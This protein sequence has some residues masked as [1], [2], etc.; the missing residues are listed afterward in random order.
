M[1]GGIYVHFPYCEHRCTYCDFVIATPRI[2]PQ[3]RFTEALLAELKLRAPQLMGPAKSL[4]LGGG[5]PSL[6]APDELARV[7]AAIR[8]EPGLCEGAEVTLEANPNDLN[9]ER[10]ALFKALGVNRISLGVQSFTDELLAT[11]GRTHTGAQAI[12]ACRAIENAAFASYSIDLIFGLPGQ[13]LSLWQAD[14]S[15]ALELDPPHLSVYGLT[16]EP[17]TPLAAQVER[18]AIALPD[19]SAQAEMMFDARRR[20]IDAGYTHYE[21]SSYAK[22]G[23][24]ARHNSAYWRMTPYLGLGPGAHAFTPPRR[25][26]NLSRTS[27]YIN[28]ALRGDPTET[29]ED[30]DEATLS[31]ERVMTGLRDLEHGVELGD[32]WARFE[33]AIERQ[34]SLGS[35]RREGRRVWLTEE[36][37]RLM[38]SVLLD[39]L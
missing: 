22:A 38:N 33:E 21:V 13:N 16:V 10:L 28:A 31:F 12:E 19:E 29:I 37:L 2:I 9:E 36:G 20:L 24:R 32:D 30:L 3:R 27:A 17:R 34:E 26:V 6:W 35:L 15:Q 4:Y 8:A 23:H 7:I 11:I 39:L 5:T 14:L 18:G 1:T 25:S